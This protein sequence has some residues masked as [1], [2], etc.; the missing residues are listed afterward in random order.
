MGPC[1]LILQMLFSSCFSAQLPIPTPPLPTFF[2][3]L[4]FPFPS[5]STFFFFF[6]KFAE[7]DSGNV[8]W[9]L[10]PWGWLSWKREIE[11]NYFPQPELSLGLWVLSLSTWQILDPVQLYKSES[12][13]L[14]KMC[15]FLLSLWRKIQFFLFNLSLYCT[16]SFL[17]NRGIL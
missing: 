5:S 17:Q 16:Q 15:C 7:G 1:L 8:F 11:I 4:C 13:I 2:L 10:P 6:F 9:H 14:E 12:L 3:Y